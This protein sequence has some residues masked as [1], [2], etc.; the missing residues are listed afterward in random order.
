[1]IELG[2]NIAL[3]GFEGKDS[4]TLVVVKK[5]VGNYARNI[6]MKQS[7]DKLHITYIDGEKSKINAK[8]ISKGEV[9]IKEAED[10]N[11]FFAL[12]NALNQLMD[13]LR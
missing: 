13:E 7:F 9:S 6:A 8:L 1:M 5:V 3:E 2:G 12:D 10:S 4:G 11:L